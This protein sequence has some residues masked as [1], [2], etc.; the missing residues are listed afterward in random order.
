MLPVLC[1]AK[2]CGWVFFRGLT[3]T[4]KKHF[5]NGRKK[6]AIEGQKLVMYSFK[7]SST[8]WFFHSLCDSQNCKLQ[9]N[10]EDKM[11]NLQIFQL[12]WQIRL[13]QALHVKIQLSFA[14]DDLSEIEEEK[15]PT[16]LRCTWLCLFYCFRYT[17]LWRIIDGTKW[18]I[19]IPPTSRDLCK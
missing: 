15:I 17:R 11:Y 9:K 18:P 12:M 7:N 16:F 8:F 14:I 1:L 13:Y 19:F 2:H 3:K 4:K 5:R 6:N 10:D